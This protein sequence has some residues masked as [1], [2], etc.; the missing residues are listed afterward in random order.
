[1]TTRILVTGANGFVGRA[2]L[3]QLIATGAAVRGAARAPDRLPPACESVAIGDIGPD[4]DWSA[5][6]RGVEVVVHMAARVHQMQD[7][8]SDSLAAFRHVN[9]AGTRRLC[10]SAIRAGVRR[11]VFVSTVKVHGEQSGANPWRESDP[12]APADPYAVSKREAEDVVMAPAHAGQFEAVVMHP[13]LVYGPGVK[14]NFL[15]LVRLIARGLPLPLGAVRN[16]RSFVGVTNFAHALAACATHPAAA[17]RTF[18]VSDLD[19]LA[20]PE[21]LRRIGTALGRP[22][23]L[24]PVP[25]PLLR[26]AARLAG[27]RAEIDRLCGN[28]AVDATA[29]GA[30]LGWAPPLTVDAELQRLATWYAT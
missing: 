2:L 12:P 14:A 10:E 21:L 16:R 29:I 7:T 18:L 8:A 20:T 28:C 26:L 3:T 4:T 23:R 5:A 22:A 30:A 1:M 9:T 6:L 24:L 15:A 27:R 19:D 13:P 11:L 17:N 25:V